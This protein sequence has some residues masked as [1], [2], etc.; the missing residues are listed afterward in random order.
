VRNFTR[1]AAGIAALV[2]VLVALAGSAS[3]QDNTIRRGHAIATIHGSLIVIA[4]DSTIYATDARTQQWVHSINYDKPVLDLSYD[5]GYLAVT[6][7]WGVLIE[8]VGIDGEHISDAKTAGKVQGPFVRA[9]LAGDI[10]I[11]TDTNNK[12]Y[13][14][15]WRSGEVAAPGPPPPAARLFLPSLNYG[16]EPGPNDPCAEPPPLGNA[17]KPAEPLHTPQ[18]CGYPPCNKAQADA[19]WGR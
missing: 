8:H 17:T 6:L 7:D 15:N 11:G 14:I 12:L 19:L 9:T 4:N 13:F 3:A 1:L 2:I 18:P 16:C 10:L 5:N